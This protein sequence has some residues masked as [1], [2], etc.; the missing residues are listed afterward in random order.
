MLLEPLYWSVHVVQEH[1]C[2]LCWGPLQ[3]WQPG[4][5]KPC[6]NLC[7]KVVLEHLDDVVSC[8]GSELD[9]EV[10]PA[11]P[12]KGLVQLLWVVGGDDQHPAIHLHHPIQHLQQTCQGQF[13]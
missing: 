3:V 1:L 11:W 8:A 2:H 13:V 12:N 4:D 5:V 10:N 6:W 9:L 7:L